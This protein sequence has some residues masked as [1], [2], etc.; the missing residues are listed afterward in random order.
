[1]GW[2]IIAGFI[3]AAGFIIWGIWAWKKKN[4]LLLGLIGI[5]AGVTFGSISLIIA[6]APS[7][8]PVNTDTYPQT[9]LAMSELA[10]EPT[11]T[12]ES[13][14]IDDGIVITNEQ[15]QQPEFDENFFLN[16]PPFE[17]HRVSLV[18]SVTMGGVRFGQALRFLTDS[19]GFSL[20][21]LRGQFTQL[22]GYLGRVD[23]TRIDS[24]AIRFIGDGRELAYFEIG[25][26]ELPIPI[27]VDVTGVQH[28]R[29]EVVGRAFRADFVFANATI[30]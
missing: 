6:I 18:D 24:S 21:N 5:I 10:P 17:M 1:M 23:G 2:L 4:S 7:R 12:T 26:G 30:R 19:N 15:S 14:L 16:A 3:I 25:A 27:S 11:I 29:I 28:L 9:T 13:E 22:S 20:H 8:E